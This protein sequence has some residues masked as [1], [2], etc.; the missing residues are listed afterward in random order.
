MT[1][2]THSHFYPLANKKAVKRYKEI[3]SSISFSFKLNPSTFCKGSN[4]LLKYRG[5]FF[6]MRN[7][8]IRI[9]GLLGSEMVGEGDPN[10]EIICDL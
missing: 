4:V 1:H 7:F 5:V 9:Y 10:M 8:V 2:K 6:F 3:A